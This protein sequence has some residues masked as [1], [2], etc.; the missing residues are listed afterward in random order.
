M[1]LSCHFYRPILDYL[2]L[3]PICKFYCALL[4]VSFFTLL[5]LYPIFFLI[6]QSPWYFV[7]VGNYRCSGYCARN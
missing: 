1:Y 7:R 6:L 4:S 2:H 5:H 3:F